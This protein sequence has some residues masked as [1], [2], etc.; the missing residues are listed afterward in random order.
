MP[1]EH[2]EIEKLLQKAFKDATIHL[3][4]T[5]GDQDHYSVHVISR[6]FAGKS[7]VEQHKMVFD[8]LQGL[9]KQDLHAL[10]VKTSLP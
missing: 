8:A 4:D 7:R 2:T 10:S 6:D 3:T 1:I 9:M 5:H